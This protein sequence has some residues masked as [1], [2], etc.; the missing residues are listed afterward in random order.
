MIKDPEVDRPAVAKRLAEEEQEEFLAFAKGLTPQQWQAPSLCHG[1]S[2]RDIVVHVASHFI[3]EPSLRT[4]V[5]LFAR[6]GFSLIRTGK[7]LDDWQRERYESLSTEDVIALLSSPIAVDS[8]FTRPFRRVRLAQRIDKADVLNQLSEMMIHQ[9]DVRRA[10]DLPR[11]IAP[12]RLRA[13]LDFNMT[14]LGALFVGLPRIVGGLRLVA[15]DL[16]W[17]AGAGAEITGPGEA[18]LMARAGRGQALADLSGPGCKTLAQR[19][20]AFTAKAEAA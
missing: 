12:D 4:A 19:I 8:S 6:G 3:R 17:T 2:T 9:Q 15:T 13:V 5:P 1:L 14:R 20:K 18:L 7:L 11:V 16:D 10:L